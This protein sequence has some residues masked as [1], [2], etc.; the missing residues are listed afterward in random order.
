MAQ[1]LHHLNCL[2]VL[3]L[4]V[5]H[6]RVF[7]SP[8]IA[9]KGGQSQWMESLRIIVMALREGLGENTLDF[10]QPRKK[11]SSISPSMTPLP[12]RL[13]RDVICDKT[14]A[15]TVAETWRPFH[16]ALAFRPTTSLILNHTLC[17]NIPET[18]CPSLRWGMLQLIIIKQ[19]H[20][21]I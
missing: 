7:G 13:S 2:R 8:C 3:N 10:P 16:D 17:L 19:N 1:P 15:S 18:C 11:C 14:F 20:F 9:K 21:P 4:M 6:F 12:G 5:S